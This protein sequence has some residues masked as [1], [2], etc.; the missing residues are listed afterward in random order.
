[1]LDGAS[2]IING[3]AIGAALNTDDTSSIA[4]TESVRSASAIAIATAINRSSA[5]TGVT[6]SAAP[7]VVRA[8]SDTA[9]TATVSAGSLHTFAI[10]G[11]VFT[12]NV[13]TVNGVIDTINTKSNLTG[14]TASSWG[15]GLQLVAADGRNIAITSGSLSA[16]NLGLGGLAIGS[17]TS[18]ATM[19]N[20]VVFTAGV[21]L[22]SDKEFT[23]KAGFSGVTNLENLGFRQ[24]TYG[25]TSDGGFK[26]QAIDVST[27]SGAAL[28]QAT[29]DAAINT[30]SNASAKTGAY[31][32]R[33]DSVVAN[34]SEM[35]QNISA[36]RSRILDTDY[37]SETTNL[38]KQ[39]IIQQAATAMLA[40]ANQSS[41]SI[42]SLL[43]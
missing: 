33:L 43:K 5:Q 10:N 3:V 2:M 4:T 23:I 26:V 17:S 24:G 35:N 41:Q 1:L 12:A 6:A 22:T 16:V 42:L 18:A 13:N 38:A 28:A 7:N 40:Q 11:F 32:N 9:F 25:S 31:L 36:S 37:A 20:A 29:I 15:S 21:K 14:V 30:V 39:Q 34:L 27:I 8:N 19:S